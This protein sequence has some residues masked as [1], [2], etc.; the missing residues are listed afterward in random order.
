MTHVEDDL[1]TAGQ[2]AESGHSPPVRLTVELKAAA[3]AHV[4]R[5]EQLMTVLFLVVPETGNE[6]GVDVS[7]RLVRH[8]VECQI[9]YLKVQIQYLKGVRFSI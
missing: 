7:E 5:L 3:R 1:K 2:T 4:H 8:V 6:R 9:Q